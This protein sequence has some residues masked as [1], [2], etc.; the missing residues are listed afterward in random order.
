LKSEAASPAKA[1]QYPA[2]DTR[3]SVRRP[4]LTRIVL[5]LTAILLLLLY[6]V[7]REHFRAMAML[8]RM[9]RQQNWITLFDRHS[10]RVLPIS[11]STPQGAIRAKVYT[12]INIQHPPAVV[13]VPGL[14]RLGMEEPRLINFAESMA[15]T[16]IEVLTPQLDALADY[17]VEPQSIDIIGHSAQELAQRAG[18]KQVGVLGLSFAGG[19]SLMAAA[20]PKYSDQISFVAAVGAQDDVQRVE[21]YL[22]E[23]QTAWPDG[24]PLTVPPHEYGWLI[25]LYSHPEDF[26]PPA[27]VDTARNSLRLLLHEDVDA[28][29]QEAQKLSPKASGLMNAVFEHQRDRFRSKLLA[30]LDKHSAEAVSVS[31]HNHLKGLKAK[32]L[33][34]HGEG[35][36]VI[37]PS[38]T[39]WLARD[40]PEGHLEEAL[41]SRAI[42]HVSL[43]DQPKWRDQVATVHWVALVLGD[44]DREPEGV[45]TTGD[46]H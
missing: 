3:A 36:D 24:R 35:D 45:E 28:A 17:R 1:Q 13:V 18:A 31:P 11:F 33:L 39:E 8:A 2:E 16:G 38:E 5:L 25:L 15:E 9:S 14:H 4:K 26:F 21:R 27:D 43:E 12:P 7:V 44:A 19:L 29:K 23:G 30:D 32:V 46:P 22:V 42:S 6:P 41:I 34:V 10:Y 37:P 20:D 40:I